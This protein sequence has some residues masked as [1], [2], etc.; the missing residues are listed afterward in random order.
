[1]QLGLL[2]FDPSTSSPDGEYIEILDPKTVSI[3]LGI[4]LE[5]I[6]NIQFINETSGNNDS[7]LPNITEIQNHFCDFILESVTITKLGYEFISICIED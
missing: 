2:Y 6:L 7:I 1:M 3:N 5:K 4:S